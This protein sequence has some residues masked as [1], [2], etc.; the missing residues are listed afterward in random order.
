MEGPGSRK[1]HECYSSWV[2]YS[3]ETCD[4]AMPGSA[5][6]VIRDP[7]RT[8]FMGVVAFRSDDWDRHSG[9]ACFRYRG[10]VSWIQLTKFLFVHKRILARLD[11]DSP[12]VFDCL[13]RKLR[14]DANAVE[15]GGKRFGYTTLGT[16]TDTVR[17]WTQVSA[18]NLGFDSLVK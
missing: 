8:G 1:S 7:P 13:L 4:S 16:P 18:E 6:I 3:C 15:V 14:F 5:S 11:G 2:G 9:W 12:I 17:I 10:V